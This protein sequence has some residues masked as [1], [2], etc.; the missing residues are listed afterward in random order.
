MDWLAV[1]VFDAAGIFGT[2]EGSDGIGNEDEAGEG[3]EDGEEADEDER[4]D[5]QAEGCWAVVAKGA[6]GF[7]V[8]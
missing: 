7:G 5:Y 4:E 3:D 2:L 1:G 8:L 6:V